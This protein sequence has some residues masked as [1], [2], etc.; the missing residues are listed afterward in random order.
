M[1]NS[2]LNDKLKESGQL[3]N[4]YLLLV[5]SKDLAIPDNFQCDAEKAQIDFLMFSLDSVIRVIARHS[6]DSE[7]KEQMFGQVKQIKQAL[8][9]TQDQDSKLCVRKLEKVAQIW[10]NLCY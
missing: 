7:T 5:K 1:I 10:S 6:S 2:K 8:E 3:F 4:R 9:N